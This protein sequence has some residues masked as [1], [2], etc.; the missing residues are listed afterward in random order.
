MLYFLW[1]RKKIYQWISYRQAFSQLSKLIGIRQNNI[2]I[3]LWCMNIFFNENNTSFLLIFLLIVEDK[4]KRTADTWWRLRDFN[5]LLLL[6]SCHLN[7]TVII[8]I[9][10]DIMYRPERIMIDLF[11]FLFSF[12]YFSDYLFSLRSFFFWKQKRFNKVIQKMNIYCIII[13]TNSRGSHSSHL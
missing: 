6:F 2:F 5:A 11:L 10:E 12:T 3:Y 4:R 7:E 13:E 1:S 9:N 8:I